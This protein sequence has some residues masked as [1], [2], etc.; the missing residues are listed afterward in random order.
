M[1]DLEAASAKV[2]EWRAAGDRIVFTNG[3]VDLL[4]PGHISLLY[5][6]R[7]LGDCLVSAS[8]PTR[9][10]GVSRA[11]AGPFSPIK[12]V[13]PCSALECVD[14]VVHFGED[15]PL[16]LIECIRP[17]I[18]VKGSDH[19]PDQVVGKA[20]VESYGGRVQL[21]DIVRGYSTTKLTERVVSESIEK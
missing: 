17:D 19:P 4:H 13:R 8:I 7:A 10:P 21:V 2:D 6:A 12:I 20:L 11:A 14:L 16:Q 15:T 3:C 1:T 9:P 18:L 5:Q